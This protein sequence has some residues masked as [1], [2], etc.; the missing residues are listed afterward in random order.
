MIF[1]RYKELLQT[2][3]L[4]SIVLLYFYIEGMYQIK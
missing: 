1:S 2:L 4:F 3:N